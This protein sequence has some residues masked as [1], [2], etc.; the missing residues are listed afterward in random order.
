M[1]Y[2]ILSKTFPLMNDSEFSALK[3]DIEQN[4]LFENIVLYEGQILDG[5][6]RYKACL[7]LGIK[8][9]Y[10]EFNGEDPLVYVVS[11]N[12]HRRHLNAYQRSLIALQ[13]KDSYKKKAKDRILAGKYPSHLN[14]KGR[15]NTL[16]GNKVNVSRGTISKVEAIEER[17][18][19]TQKERV[20]AGKSSIN[21]VY[22]EIKRIDKKDE[23]KKLPQEKLQ[24]KYNVILADPPWQYAY[25]ATSLR[26]VAD[27][28]YPTMDIEAIK[29]LPVKNITLDNAVLF[30]WTTTT[31]IRKAF[32]VVE[33]WGF[34]FKTSMVW[35]KQ[36]F[37]TG[38][39]VR[40]KHEIILIGI[41]GHFLPM[42]TDIPESVFHAKKSEHS[43]KPEKIYEIIEKMYPD[44][45][46]I[47]L[48]QRG[49]KRQTWD[50]WGSE[51]GI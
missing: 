16:L 18:T 41:K 7:A 1:E 44:Q 50:V 31:M 14:D 26:G 46:K 35:V 47:E 8:P 45:R 29:N 3:N 22:K 32:D 42:T 33:A 49:A 23:I 11:Q 15:V 5:R 13:L 30:L 34:E 43:K 37:G 6:N 38:F 17:A 19:E 40:G 2:H 9:K 51:S 28:H 10:T 12:L 48:F 27:D 24:G 25:N 4:G 39:Y 36:H 21:A 20:V